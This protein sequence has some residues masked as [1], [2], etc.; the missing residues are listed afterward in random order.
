[1]PHDPRPRAAAPRCTGAPFGLPPVL[2][3]SRR[4]HPRRQQAKPGGAAVAAVS[5]GW[6]WSVTAAPA[7]AVLP[8]VLRMAMAT[9]WRTAD[10]G[11][12]AQS[13]PHGLGWAMICLLVFPA[14]TTSSV[15][16]GIFTLHEGVWG[17]CP[18]HGG[19]GRLLHQ[20]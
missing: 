17:I 7:P 4:R 1:M 9:L 15:F 13:G 14:S 12:W 6:I 19:G 16:P 2:L 10:G 5:L 20:R 8:A 11:R 3:S 18:K